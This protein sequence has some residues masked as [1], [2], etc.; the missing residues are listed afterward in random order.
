MPPA[1][2]SSLQDLRLPVS[3]AQRPPAQSGQAG[4]KPKRITY[5]HGV[6]LKERGVILHGLE[7]LARRC[8]VPETTREGLNSSRLEKL[9][10]LI[11]LI[12]RTEERG[13]ILRSSY[14]TIAAKLHTSESTVKDLIN[15]VNCMGL[16]TL[17]FQDGDQ[18]YEIRSG[19]ALH[20]DA[21]AQ[22]LVD[23]QRALRNRVIRNT[24]ENVVGVGSRSWKEP[25]RYPGR[26][27]YDKTT[28][29]VH[30]CH[31]GEVHLGA[32]Q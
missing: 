5:L 19:P 6:A 10:G 20:P 4:G 31:R 26:R 14:G 29:V 13:Q 27:Q 2:A 7:A 25:R 12:L 28:P 15:K 18:M 22:L 24:K 17:Q 30:P 21:W 3:T 1:I 9:L 32:P 23:G 11:Q 16:Y 8:G